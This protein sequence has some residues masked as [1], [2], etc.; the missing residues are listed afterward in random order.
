MAVF[1]SIAA[2]LGTA[3]AATAGAGAAA[4]AT[5][6]A[7]AGAGLA[8]TLGT[9]G[10][11]VGTGFQVKGAL[12]AQAAQDKMERLRKAQMDLESTRQRRQIVRQAVVAR[13]EALS[14]A[15]SQGASAGSGLQ[16]G[17]AQISGEARS[18]AGAVDDNQFLGRAMFK[19]NRQLS[20]AQ[21]V[22]TIG[23]GIS[24]LT[25]ALVKNQN[26]IGRV[27]TYYGV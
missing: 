4:G 15:T 14:N 18:A 13:S 16:G 3:G 9:I 1:S 22:Q 19:A 24:S 12:D 6:A 10:S 27:G 25:G 17:F 2:A 7:T 20:R 8:G 23:S 5:G 26:E 21:T 11:L